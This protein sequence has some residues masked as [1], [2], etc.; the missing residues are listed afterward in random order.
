MWV[1]QLYSKEN[2]CPSWGICSNGQQSFSGT[3]LQ[4]DCFMWETCFGFGSKGLAL[5]FPAMYLCWQNGCTK[6]CIWIGTNRLH[7]SCWGWMEECGKPS[8]AKFPSVWAAPLYY[9][10]ELGYFGHHHLLKPFLIEEQ[11]KPKLFI[12]LFL[13]CL[14]HSCQGLPKVGRANEPEKMPGGESHPFSPPPTHSL[15]LFEFW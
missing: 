7:L 9:G 15:L 12:L 6:C 13:G 11:L 4:E 1:A 2:H 3:L 5:S 14:I 8:C 10:I